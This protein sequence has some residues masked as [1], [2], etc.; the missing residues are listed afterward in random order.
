MIDVSQAVEHEHPYALEFLRKDCTNI[1]G[2]TIFIL[3]IILLL[4]SNLLILGFFRHN[5]VA[6]LTIKS[7]FDFLTD[8]TITLDNMEIC[9]D[10]LQTNMVNGPLTNEEIIE[11][12][13]FKNA[14]IPKNL[15]E[16]HFLSAIFNSNEC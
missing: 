13:V 16:V 10:R 11:Q 7:L 2:K 8:P 14:Y 15:N 4:M 6:T 12:E 1:T 9:L 5:D 3:L